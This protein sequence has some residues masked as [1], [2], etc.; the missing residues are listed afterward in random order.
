ME[1]FS[2]GI[3]E[4]STSH[5]SHYH[6]AS[7]LCRGLHCGAECS[8]YTTIML[9]LC[10]KTLEAQLLDAR[11][12][13]DER[14]RSVRVSVT[15]TATQQGVLIEEARGESEN[16]EES[17]DASVAAIVSEKK[18]S[19]HGDASPVVSFITGEQPFQKRVR[20]TKFILLR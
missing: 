17:E 18:C 15:S 3:C 2:A 6:L 9:I 20:V 5:H 14:E 12:G 4:K 16:A 19:L 1:K 11:A 7:V 13:E 10:W 8:Q